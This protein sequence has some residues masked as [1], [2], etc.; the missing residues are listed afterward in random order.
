MNI[1]SNIAECELEYTKCFSKVDDHK[2]FL[3]FK[4]DLIP[5]MWYHNYTWIKNAYDDA[6]LIR[7]IESEITHSKNNG[8]NFCL[9]RCHVP[10]SPSIPAQLSQEPE[11]STEGYYVFDVAKLPMMSETKGSRVAKIDRVEMMEDLLKLDLEHDEES[12]GK[13]F[14]TRRVYRRKDVY[15]SDGGL[16]CYICYYNDIPVGS[17]NLFMHGDIAKIE[18]FA[19]SPN[20]Q[21]KGFGM[22]I[23]KTLIEIALR[24]NVTT[25]YLETSED[26]TAKE[27]YMKCGFYK[28]GEFI[29]L[30]FQF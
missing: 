21:R 5:D 2:D 1:L 16:D 12:L 18:D 13:D 15:L 14:C 4:D 28:V 24:N 7:L 6:A 23:L 29:D 27:M 3:R 17:C 8:R 19:V 25:I 10:I 26:E 22:T 11:I 20:H 9:L 30:S